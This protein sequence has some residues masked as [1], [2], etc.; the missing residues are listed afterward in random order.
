MVVR[1]IKYQQI[2][3]KFFGGGAKFVNGAFKGLKYTLSAIVDGQVGK[4][5][6][7]TLVQL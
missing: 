6:F 4:A 2:L 7:M 3:Q 1:L 5:N